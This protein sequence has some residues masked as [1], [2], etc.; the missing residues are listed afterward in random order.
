ML[1]LTISQISFAD[2][3]ICQQLSESTLNFLRWSKDLEATY[4]GYRALGNLLCTPFGMHTSA[5][6]VS[7]DAVADCLRVHM[8]ADLPAGFEKINEIS[9][10]IINAL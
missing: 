1:N 6:I 5:L 4:R 9:R 2:E 10:D 8:S 7:A 3:K